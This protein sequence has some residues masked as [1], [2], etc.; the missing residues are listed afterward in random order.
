MTRQ[1]TSILN[2]LIRVLDGIRSQCWIYVMDCINEGMIGSLVV[3]MGAAMAWWIATVPCFCRRSGSL[4]PLI[5][6]FIDFSEQNVVL[7]IMPMLGLKVQKPHEQRTIPCEWW[8]P[9]YGTGC[10]NWCHYDIFICF[11]HALTCMTTSSPMRTKTGSGVLDHSKIQW[12]FPL[13]MD[14]KNFH[15]ANQIQKYLNH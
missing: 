15:A 5:Q 2:R 13:L 11:P 14:S 9:S 10:V 1:L 6:D 4:E 12:S 8:C 3:W 7:A